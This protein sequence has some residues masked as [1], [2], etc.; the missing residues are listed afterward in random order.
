MSHWL[1]KELE[2]L[3]D[4]PTPP[5]LVDLEGRVW[6]RLELLREEKRAVT[7][8]FLPVRVAAVLVALG[9]GVAGGTLSAAA[10]VADAPEI[11]AFS[12]RAHLAPSTLL[13]GHG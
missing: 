4:E 2:A 12:L 7:A 13:E 5:E 8:M 11:S 1:D 10:A 3:R 6:R 9:L